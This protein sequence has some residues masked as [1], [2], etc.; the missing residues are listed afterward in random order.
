MPNEHLVQQRAATSV[1]YLLD[2][3]GGCLKMPGKI[4]A[5]FLNNKK[6]KEEFG[7]LHRKKQN[8]DVIR[9]H[10]I[11]ANPIKKPEKIGGASLSRPEIIG[12]LPFTFV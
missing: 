10:T 5:V 12:R 7:N 2:K 1:T 3:G 4:R 6:N 11:W 8:R 9:K